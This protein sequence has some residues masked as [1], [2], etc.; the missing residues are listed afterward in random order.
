MR[1]RR[2]KMKKKKKKKKGRVE[3]KWGVLRVD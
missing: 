1:R 2:W 3:R